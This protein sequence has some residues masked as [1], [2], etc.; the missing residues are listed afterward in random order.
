MI[1]LFKTLGIRREVNTQVEAEVKLIPDLP[2][3]PVIRE[4]LQSVPDIVAE[5]WFS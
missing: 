5:I 4:T 1:S 3:D 2:A